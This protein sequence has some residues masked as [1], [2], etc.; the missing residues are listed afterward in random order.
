MT[1]R[2]V[3][4]LTPD[5][6]AEVVVFTATRREN[7]VVADTLI[8]PQH[9]VS[10]LRRMRAPRAHRRLGIW[11]ADEIIP[12]PHPVSC[13]RSLLELHLSMRVPPWSR[14]PQRLELVPS[15]SL[16]RPPIL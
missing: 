6:I 13:T 14:N 7:V 5:D 12:R 16:A 3:E 10:Y 8:F 4:P 9:Q 11:V 2:G 15:T 1:N